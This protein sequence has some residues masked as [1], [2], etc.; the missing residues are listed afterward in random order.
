[1]HWKSRIIR[2]EFG[3]FC[4]GK[5]GEWYDRFICTPEAVR[6]QAKVRQEQK[7]FGGFKFSVGIPHYNRGALIYRPLF[8]LLNHPAVAE[9]VIVD[10]G[11]REEEFLKL[12]QFVNSLG[13]GERV[14][15]FRREENRRALLTKLEL[16]LI[17]I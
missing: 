15:V 4:F 9:V 7:A 11:S 3:K 17:H 2:S 8:N 12:Q 1:M 6:R 14:K 10:D 5:A 16:S 13:C